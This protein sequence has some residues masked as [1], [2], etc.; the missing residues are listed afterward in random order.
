MAFLNPKVI[1]QI[2]ENVFKREERTYP[3]DYNYPIKENIII[4]I[5]LPE[6]YAVNELPQKLAISMPNRAARY[7]FSV[8]SQEKT[9][10]LINQYEINQTIFPE[11]EYADLRQF[12]QMIVG[13][14]AEQIVIT[15]K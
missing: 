12:N 11:N 13:K 7:K 2:T 3:V 6:G 14:E 8:H 10:R 4:T 9:I 15:K 1:K 5:I